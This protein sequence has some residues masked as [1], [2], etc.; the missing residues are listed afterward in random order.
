MHAPWRAKPLKDSKLYLRLLI[1]CTKDECT[2]CI[3]SLH[4]V[5][6]LEIHIHVLCIIMSTC[7]NCINY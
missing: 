5:V 1:C 6:L 7:H 2:V 3:L 4:F